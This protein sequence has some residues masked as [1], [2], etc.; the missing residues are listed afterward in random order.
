MDFADFGLALAIMDQDRRESPQWSESRD[1]LRHARTAERGWLSRQ[2]CR[3][4]CEL[5]ALRLVLADRLAGY[6]LAQVFL[7]AERTG[8]LSGNCCG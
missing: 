8:L 3:L 1:M 4:R 2:I 6:G 7:R 5:D